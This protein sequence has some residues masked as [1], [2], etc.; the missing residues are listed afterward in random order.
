MYS[1]FIRHAVDFNRGYILSPDI[2]WWPLVRRCTS[3]KFISTCPSNSTKIRPCLTP[4]ICEPGNDWFR[5]FFVTQVHGVYSTRKAVVWLHYEVY[6][7]LVLYFIT[8]QRPE[9][10]AVSMLALERRIWIYHSC[11]KLTFHT[12]HSI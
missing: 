1:S 12:L 6:T 5:Y 10:L 4:P 8:Y 3:P 9:S 11:Y 7:G 2:P